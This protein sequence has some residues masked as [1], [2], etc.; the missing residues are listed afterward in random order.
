MH[1]NRT[2]D[3]NIEINAKCYNC[4]EIL[5]AVELKQHDGFLY[6]KPCDK[7]WLTFPKDNLVV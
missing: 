5:E 2:I 6:I 4:D 1:I 7:C 3:V